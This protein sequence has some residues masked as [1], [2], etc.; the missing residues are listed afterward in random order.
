MTGARSIDDPEALSALS[1]TKPLAA[2]NELRK[3]V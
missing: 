3:V 2:R 1:S